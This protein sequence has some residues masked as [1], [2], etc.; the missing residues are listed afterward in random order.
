MIIQTKIGLKSSFKHLKYGTVVSIIRG[1]AV[2]QAFVAGVR[3]LH[4]IGPV[5][6]LIELHVRRIIRRYEAP[7]EVADSPVY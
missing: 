7:S 3:S 4:I 5:E 1:W 2:G 6:I